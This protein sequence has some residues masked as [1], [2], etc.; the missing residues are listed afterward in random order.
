MMVAG[1]AASLG[2]VLAND[3]RLK[4]VFAE[5]SPPSMPVVMPSAGVSAGANTTARE[6]VTRRFAFAALLGAA[7]LLLAASLPAVT[8]LASSLRS[9]SSTPPS[10]GPPMAARAGAGVSG[11]WEQSYA[12]AQ[13]AAGLVGGAIIAGAAAQHAW[14]VLN[15]MNTIAAERAAAD[16]GYSVSSSQAAAAPYT[17][18]AASG[19]AAGTVIRARVTIYG[20]TGPGGGFCNHMATGGNAFQGA[21]ACSYNLPFGTKLTIA[22]DPTGRV[23]ECL[24]R[25]MLSPTWIDVYFED[26]ADGIAWQSQLGSTLADIQIVN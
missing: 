19:L 25:G 21:A 12:N 8:A 15:A 9:P 10:F 7:V 6:F 14:D 13:P 26:T 1:T 20:C 24:D 4:P 16:Q 11:N 22:G 23:Y 2:L 3:R 17:L 5:A 18:N